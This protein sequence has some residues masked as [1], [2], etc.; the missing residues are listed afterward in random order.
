MLMNQLNP[1]TDTTSAAP[2]SKPV[3]QLFARVAIPV[4]LFRLFDYQLPQQQP[5]ELIGLRVEVP[6]G[7]RKIVGFIIETKGSS[8]YQEN[9]IKPIFR[10]LDETPLLQP[11]TLR[12]AQWCSSYYLFPIGETIA[13]MVPTALRQGKP[14]ERFQGHHWSL[15]PLGQVIL[16]EDLN[17][18]S[19]PQAKVL[20]LLAEHE[21]ASRAILNAFEI[22]STTLESLEKKGFIQRQL[23]EPK[24]RTQHQW[25][26]EVPPS[27]TEEQ[28]QAITEINGNTGFHLLFGVTG[29][30]KTEVYMGL[31]LKALEKGQQV[32]VLV[33]EIGLTPQTLARFSKRF[34]AQIAILHSQ[35][36]ETERTQQWMSAASGD[37]DIIIGTRSAVFTPIPKLGLIVLDEE[38]DQSYKQQ[39][40]MRYSARDLVLLRASWS[41]VSAVLGSATPSLE[42]LHNVKQKNYYLHVLNKRAT[43]VSMPELALIDLRR[44]ATEQGIAK[45]ILE[46]IKQTL[47]EGLQVLIFLN[48]RGFAPAVI[49]NDCG[50]VA[51]CPRCDAK[52]TMHRQSCKLACHH[53][54]YHCRIPD[55]CPMCSS[56][57][58]NAHGKGTERVEETLESH[59]KAPVI[60]V[61]RDTMPNQKAFQKC[62]DQVNTGEPMILLGTQMLSKGHD[63]QGVHLVVMLDMDGGLFSSDFRAEERTSQLLAQVTGRAGR[64]TLA[65]K[66]IVQTY[67]PQHPV[68]QYWI[69]QD[70]HQTADYLLSQREA[71]GLPPYSFHILLRAEATHSATSRAFLVNAREAFLGKMAQEQIQVLGPVNAAMERRAGVHRFHLLLQGPNRKALHQLVRQCYHQIEGSPEARKVRWGFEIDPQDF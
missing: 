59:F 24:S 46:R 61:D 27:L 11:D 65:G 19:K 8:D 23:Q 9:K 34:N 14:L 17:K 36:N 28:S 40:G 66:V 35:Q 71:T 38:H 5:A 64:G 53:C 70:Y 41:G 33:P 63:F 6:F 12:L 3:D 48:R 44:E 10:F 58:L 16:Q 21:H 69:A 56:L 2:P 60:R 62:L 25:L 7:P 1:C 57:H 29:S 42:I 32:L 20:E 49:C 50:W 26:A 18:Q 67:Q 30:G 54:E 31:I 15:T 45:T 39:D 37:A 68:F 13:A 55:E 51:N 43:G 4:P 52:L 22:K 47:Q